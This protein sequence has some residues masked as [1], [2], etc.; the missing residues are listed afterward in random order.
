MTIKYCIFNA[1]R[2][3]KKKNLFRFL[4][5]KK[6]QLQVIAPLQRALCS[7][8]CLSGT[9]FFF[10]HFKVWVLRF[11]LYLMVSDSLS[12]KVLDSVYFII[13]GLAFQLC[14]GYSLKVKKQFALSSNNKGE[15]ITLPCYWDKLECR[16]EEKFS[17]YLVS[18]QVS[19]LCILGCE[20]LR[21][22]IWMDMAISWKS[23]SFIVT[24]IIVVVSVDDDHRSEGHSG[25]LLAQ[26]AIWGILDIFLWKH[27]T[28]ILNIFH[29]RFPLQLIGIWGLSVR[30]GSIFDIIFI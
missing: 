28:N 24:I 12:S 27:T 22:T 18:V 8:N 9:S 13:V 11:S 15:L 4:K 21:W 2:Q 29:F 14:K 5:K 6:K 7:L 16:V 17:S 23:F 26:H 3:W 1:A 30:I 20:S 10:Y 25:G 19:G